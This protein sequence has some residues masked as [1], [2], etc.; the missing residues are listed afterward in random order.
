[1]SQ[2]NTMS[3]NTLNWGKRTHQTIDM[4]IHTRTHNCQVRPSYLVIMRIIFWTKIKLR[5]DYLGN[6][7]HKSILKHYRLKERG[8]TEPL[9]PQH[10][11]DFMPKAQCRGSWVLYVLSDSQPVSSSRVPHTV[12]STY[13]TS[14][15]RK[16]Q[17]FYQVDYYHHPHFTLSNLQV[18]R[19]C[20]FS[21]IH[22][23]SAVGKQRSW[24]S[25]SSK[26]GSQ[27][28]S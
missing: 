7:H 25:H 9:T 12:L 20:S 14:G 1:M 28:F 22:S 5:R 27:Q 8:A 23:R 17:L 11:L 10:D 15:I 18:T 19:I 2:L 6:T 16:H 21:F 4:H 26:S 3:Q 24:N 13:G